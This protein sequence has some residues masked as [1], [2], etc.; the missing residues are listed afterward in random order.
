MVAL[1]DAITLTS[2]LGDSIENGEITADTI[3]FDSIAD[4]LT[5]DAE[6]TISAS[7][8]LNLLIGNNVT[9]G[10]TGTGVITASDVAAD[11]VALGADTTG[12][13]V[14][15]IADAGSS[16]ITVTGS[17][18]ETA[19]VTL[20]VVDVNCTDCLNSTEIED[21]FVSNTGDA[22]AGT[23]DIAETVGG[24]TSD[25]LLSVTLTNTSS[26]GTQNG[27]V[28]GNAASTGTTEALLV[29]DNSD[30]DTAVTTAFQI[31]DAGGGF[32][33][34]FDVGGTL[35]FGSRIHDS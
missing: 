30:T 25:N 16:T 33:N 4:S 20:D 34:L 26:S 9:L 35:I 29:L 27:L 3:D 12:N 32:T 10:T 6:T 11:S 31:V 5:L 8:A 21:I 13:Y 22:I 19:G 1:G 14:A 2:L 18:S 7:S 15:T 24:T 17:G 23:L 28:I